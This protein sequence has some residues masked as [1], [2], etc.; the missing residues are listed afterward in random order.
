MK[1]LN[2][3]RETKSDLVITITIFCLPLKKYAV[4][5]SSSL[6]CEDGTQSR[7][8]GVLRVPSNGRHCARTFLKLFFT[9]PAKTIAREFHKRVPKRQQR[10]AQWGA[11][12]TINLRDESNFTKL[13]V[14]I[15]ARWLRWPR[16]PFFWKNVFSFFLYDC[17]WIRFK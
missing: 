3:R 4:H 17:G 15:K 6:K 9:N 10:T 12:W 16:W 5:C 1:V 13:L 11:I 8:C 2:D 14:I 7:V